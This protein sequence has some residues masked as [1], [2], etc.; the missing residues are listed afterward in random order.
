MIVSQTRK[1]IINP[2]SIN[3]EIAEKNT[4]HEV[5]EWVKTIVF[6]LVFAIVLRIFVFEIVVVNQTSMFPTLE[7]GDRLCLFKPVYALSTP[8]RGDITVI[9][10]DKDLNYVKRVVGL[11]GETVSINN[12]VVYING[13]ALDESYLRTG[14]VYSDYPETIVPD[15]CYFV[16]GD[17]RPNSEDSRSSRVG[18]IE[19]ERFVGKVV[20]RFYPFKWFA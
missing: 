5:I 1:A 20:L 15:G 2:M 17:N 8:K 14:L 18:F 6:A 13:N 4:G 10:I 11:P 16:M 12:G 7:E 3:H 9:K 19:K